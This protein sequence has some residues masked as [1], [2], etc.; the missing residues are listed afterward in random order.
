[1]F[2]IPAVRL[3]EAQLGHTPAVWTYRFSWRTP[4]LGGK[5]GACHTLELPFVFD[6]VHQS[7]AFVGS[8]PPHD[9]AMG[10]H[11]SWVRFA[12]TGD[13]NG[14]GLLPWPAYEIGTRHVMDFDTITTVVTDPNGDERRLWAGLM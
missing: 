9:L 13:P 2:T 5:L 3:A 11:G 12:S 1:M 7:D 6:N 8:E 14:A 4:V 10:M